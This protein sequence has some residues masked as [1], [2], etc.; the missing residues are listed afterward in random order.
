MDQITKQLNSGIADFE[1]DPSLA[2]QISGHE[3]SGHALN[4]E[5]S[6]SLLLERRED[7]G[8]I[9]KLNPSYKAPADYKPLLRE[10]KVPIP[11]K[12][13]P[14]YNF[15]SLVFGPAS[16]TQ[17]RLEKETGAK[18]RVFGTKSNTGKKEVT[19][20]EIDTQSFYEE[21]YVHVSADTYE[22]VD[23]AVALIDLLV[24]PV[25]V[26][27]VAVSTT[28]TSVSSD[29]MN[30]IQSSQG[31]PISYTVLTSFVNQGVAQP[32]IGSV[33]ARPLGQFQPYQGPWFPTSSPL[34]FFTPQ[35]SSA[36]ILSS[37][38]HVSSAP[39][40]AS[41][42][43]SLFGPRP[44]GFGSVAQNP[45]FIPSRPQPVLQ[46][47][48]VS[49][50]P[51]L[52][53]IGP[54]SNPTMP[55]LQPT[56]GH[57][58]ISAPPP[59]SGNQHSP[60]GPPQVM[61]SL[62]PR[63]GA[64]ATFA[65]QSL[66][67]YGSS[68][69]WSQAPTV[70]SNMGQMTLSIVPPQR[71]H[72]RN[73]QPIVMSGAPPFNNTSSHMISP[74]TSPFQPSTSRSSGPSFTSIPQP[75]M[76]FAP[77]SSSAPTLTRAMVPTMSS[78][79]VLGTAQIPLPVPSTST[80]P[81][82]P[83]SGVQNS[84]SGSAAP[85]ATAPKPLHPSSNDFTFQP[86][87]PQNPAPQMASRPSIQPAPHNMPPRSLAMLSPQ[88]PISSFLLPG[89]NSAPSPVM[90]GFSRPQDSGQMSQPRPQMSLSSAGNLNSPH[91]PSRHPAFP[92]PGSESPATPVPQMGMRNYSPGPQVMNLA[93]PFVLR[94]G[95]PMQLQQNYLPMAT[96]PRGHLSP[97]QQFNGGLPFPSG[98]QASNSFAG[99]QNYDPF[100]PTYVPLRPQLGANP[101]Q[102]RKQES[103]PEYEDLM[104]SVGVK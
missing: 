91:G 8:E 7:I 47:S 90:Q 84:V 12:D 62:M 40:N 72:P 49:Q 92:S 2:S 37:A 71:P 20:D 44:A 102:P 13:Y 93:G 45:S 51:S 18:I 79:P 54:S 52:G 43:P 17:K 86:H 73:S 28:S 75:Q 15:L 100:S 39:L 14:G 85:S 9:L 68:T 83:Q 38:A 3:S 48:Y 46:H 60:T 55:A 76:G 25:S 32:I 6:Q 64:P 87:R 4:T 63:S 56:P 58:N 77:T 74:I 59:F 103:D 96:R 99:Q 23:T 61:G 94:P 10:A 104:A 41:N 97:N 27:P 98:N 78:N 69:V 42:I 81:L 21:L 95:N 26:N 1:D 57:P 80:P 70:P 11:I 66:T 89:Q 36:P 31:T 67:H 30:V 19:V 22:K 65:A 53:Y 82:L 33:Q 29:N 34:G 16:D 88:A 50:A 35:N 24:T 5:K 101:L